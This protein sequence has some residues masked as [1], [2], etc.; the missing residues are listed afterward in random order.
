MATWFHAHAIDAVAYVINPNRN[1]LQFKL[2][3]QERHFV[4]ST[5][6]L[7]DLNYFG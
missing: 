7:I 1:L 4:C 3:H 2:Q 6:H 5:F